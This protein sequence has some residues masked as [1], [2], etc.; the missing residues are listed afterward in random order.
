MDCIFLC[1]SYAAA[2]FFYTYLRIS[3]GGFAIPYFKSLPLMVFSCIL[4]FSAFGIYRNMWG[5]LSVMDLVRIAIAA[6]LTSITSYVYMKIMRG[7][8]AS[9]II[10]VTG[11]YI[12]LSL[13]IGV[14]I[15]P[16]VISNTKKYFTLRT[17]GADDRIPLL[18]VGAGEA[19]A[20]LIKDLNNQGDQCKYKIIGIVDDDISKVK[21]TLRR[22]PIIGTSDNIHQIIEK[23][24]IKEIVIAIPSAT[25]EERRKLITICSST[26]CK[27]R[28]INAISDMNEAKVISFKK[29]DANDL[30]GRSEVSLNPQDMATYITG[31]TILVTGG[32]G[33]I[34]SELCRQIISFQPSLLVI[35]DIYENNSYDIFNELKYLYPS[36]SNRI[37]VRIGSVQ[38]KKRLDQV[39]C[40][41][42]PQVVFHAAA[43][44]HV[45]LME[46]CPELA[47]QNNVFGTYNTA[48]CSLQYGIHRFVMISTDKAVNPTN[49]MGASKRISEI[50]IQSMNG[51]GTEFVAVRFGNVLGSNGSVV[52][53]FKRQIERG[54]PVTITHPNIIRYFMTIPEAARLVLQAGAIAR[55]GETFVLDMGEPVKIVD[56]AHSMIEMAGLEPNVDIDICFTGLRPGEKLYE[57]LLLSHE[58]VEKTNDDKIYVAHSPFISNQ[59]RWSMLDELNN[60]I[61][62]KKDIRNCIKKLLPSYK[63]EN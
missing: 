50:I 8:W 10:G 45:P 62:Q 14:R 54:G 61:E 17:W 15:L 19:G 39:F 55:G 30:L 36:Y 35:Y 59:E 60:V 63:P 58:N 26:G 46:E 42:R 47:I 52:P 7:A 3:P 4:I 25:T 22:I 41:I 23:Y 20:M 9:P 51:Q 27:V 28:M 38:D 33:S 2:I 5:F 48:A 43:Y 37:L 44:K 31:R 24:Q 49:I 12:F 11:F 40:E 21:H 34:G 56:L 29:L 18:I 6:G 57:E 13:T 32:G 53:I 16:S 1:I